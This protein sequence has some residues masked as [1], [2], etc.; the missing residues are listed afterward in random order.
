MCFV[1][2]LLSI[3][4]VL[5]YIDKEKLHLHLKYKNISPSPYPYF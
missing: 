3:F 5:K 2:T 4:Y 1:V